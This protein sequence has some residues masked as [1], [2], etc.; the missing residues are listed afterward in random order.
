MQSKFG[1]HGVY[2]FHT[3]RS[4]AKGDAYRYLKMSTRKQY[5]RYGGKLVPG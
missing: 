5:L 3:S 1:Q 2:K 4:I